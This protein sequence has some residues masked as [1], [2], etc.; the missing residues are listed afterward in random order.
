MPRWFSEERA[1]SE[2]FAR[3]VEEPASVEG[4][5]RELDLVTG[6]RELGASESLDEAT[7]RR[8]RAGIVERLT[9]PDLEAERMEP[10]RKHSAIGGLLV[11]AAAVLIAL[12]GLGMLLSKNALPGDPLYGV[13]RASESVAL[14]LTFGQQ[15]KAQKYLEFA[16]NRLDELVE[17]KDSGGDSA[18]YLTGLTDFEADARAGVAQLTALA[19]AN[20]GEQQLAGLRTWAQERAGALSAESA[21]IPAAAVSRFTATQVLLTD[22]ET[23]ATALAD[24]LGCYRITSGST[25]E[26]G[27]L[28]AEGVCDQRSTPSVTKPPTGA[29]PSEPAP[30]EDSAQTYLP[31]DAVPGSETPAQPTVP[32]PPTSSITPPPV[33]APP[34]LPTTGPRLPSLPPPPPPLVSLPPLLPGLPPIVIP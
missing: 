25:D 11:A 10:R 33:I 17:L 21:A 18:D 5:A 8:I 3:A 31:T 24:R 19:T 29:T 26:L 32:L 4:F 1:D 15:A 28:P 14:G 30:V 27:A 23:R 7:R 6:L 12:A 20:S 22:I 2:R 9:E 34:I 16:D 13:K